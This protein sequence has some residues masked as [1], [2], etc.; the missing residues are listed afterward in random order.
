MAP[1]TL[2]HWRSRTE[3]GLGV[4]LLAP[5]IP[6]RLVGAALGLFAA[7]MVWTSWHAPRTTSDGQSLAGDDPAAASPLVLLAAIGAAL[8]LDPGRRHRAG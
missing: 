1:E 8:A 3:M 4:A 2:A 6:A 7:G 5:P